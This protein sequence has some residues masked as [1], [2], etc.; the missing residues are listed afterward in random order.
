MRCFP[1]PPGTLADAFEKSRLI[2]WVKFWELG[3][4]VLAG[5]GFLTGNFAVLM[6]VLF[7]LGVQATF[8]SPL[9]YG[10]LPDLL[11]GEELVAGNGLVEAGTFVGILLG[12]VAGGALVLVPGGGLGSLGNLSRRVRLRDCERVQHPA[13]AGG[14]A[15]LAAGLEYRRANLGTHSQCL[16]Q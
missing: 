7:G 3:L 13:S 8:F 16:P 4:M 15:G 6:A 1:P 14:A 2:R 10:I 9:K 11:A 12:T 5:I